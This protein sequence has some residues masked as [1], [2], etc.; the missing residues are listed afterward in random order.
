M[1]WIDDHQIYL[2]LYFVFM[3]GEVLTLNT[4]FNIEYRP[5]DGILMF[6]WAIL[7]C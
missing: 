1:G 2:D 7:R 4:F 3:L 6:L 5:C